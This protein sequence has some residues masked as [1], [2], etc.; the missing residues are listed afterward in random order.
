MPSSPPQGLETLPSPQYYLTGPSEVPVSQDLPADVWGP[1]FDVALSCNAKSAP[2]LVP[3]THELFGL[4][5]TRILGM[6]ILQV[7]VGRR[8]R[9]LHSPF[10]A[11]G[12]AE[13]LVT[14]VAVRGTALKL[15]VANRAAEPDGRVR[16]SPSC[17]NIG[18]LRECHPGTLA[19]LVRPFTDLS[20]PSAGL[21]L[22]GQVCV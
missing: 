8:S 1:V 21:E 17:S 11:R 18:A 15:L 3:T 10:G 9:T 22:C 20:L 14:V 16:D 13:R 5:K 6:D 2:Q 4:L 19:D 12:L 7:F